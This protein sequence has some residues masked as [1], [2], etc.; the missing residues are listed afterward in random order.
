[1]P[2]GTPDLFG[3]AGVVST[4]LTPDE[5]DVWHDVDLNLDGRMR[6]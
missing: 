3:V 2:D 5:P 1:M 4:A 6:W